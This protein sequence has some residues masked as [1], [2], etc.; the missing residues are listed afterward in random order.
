MLGGTFSRG[1]GTE[2][3]RYI[4][5][6]P[7][8]NAADLIVIFRDDKSATEENLHHMKSSEKQRKTPE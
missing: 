7:R 5:Q 6:A 8:K 1:P 2:A 3:K 4:Q